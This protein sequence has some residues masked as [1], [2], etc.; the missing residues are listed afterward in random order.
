[1]MAMIQLTNE[2]IAAAFRL[3]DADVHAGRMRLLS[4]EPAARAVI[5]PVLRNGFESSILAQGSAFGIE[6]RRLAGAGEH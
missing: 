1:M 3:S 5:E 6:L 2:A 4:S